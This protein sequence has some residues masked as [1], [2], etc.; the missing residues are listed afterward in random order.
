MVRLVLED[1]TVT[2]TADGLTP[3]FII[4]WR[5]Q[6]ADL[7]R[8]LNAWQL[9][10]TSAEIVALIDQ[11]LDRYTANGVAIELNA[12]GYL[13]GTGRPSHGRIMQNIQRESARLPL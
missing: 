10:E 9:H 12:R 11:L 13:S 4:R 1:V 5:D 7:A 8:A 2:N 3:I 6:D